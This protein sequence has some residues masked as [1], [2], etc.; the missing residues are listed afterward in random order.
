MKVTLTVCNVCQDKDRSTRQYEVR[1]EDGRKSK[2]DLCKEHA[3]PLEV[4]LNSGAPTRI[5]K[6]AAASPRRARKRVMTLEEIEAE[7]AAG[8]L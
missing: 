4:F 3:E 5:A 8:R 6:K 7:K 1:S 2:P